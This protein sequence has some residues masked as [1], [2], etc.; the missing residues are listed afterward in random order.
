MNWKNVESE[1]RERIREECALSIDDEIKIF[2]NDMDN[3]PEQEIHDRLTT[4]PNYT[5]FGYYQVHGNY[6]TSEYHGSFTFIAE[7][8]LRTGCQVAMITSFLSVI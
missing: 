3:L 5:K 2:I 6:E 1:V 8:D 4:C 7:V